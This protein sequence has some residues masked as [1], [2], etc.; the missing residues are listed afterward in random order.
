MVTERDL[1]LGDEHTIQY[2]DDVLQ[3]CIRATYMS[4]LTNITPLNSIP[5]RNK[6]KRKKMSQG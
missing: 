3:N 1:T 2:T 5:F 6:K 4:V